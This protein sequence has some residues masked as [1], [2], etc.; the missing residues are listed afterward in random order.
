MSRADITNE[1]LDFY[2]A[3]RDREGNTLGIIGP[4]PDSSLNTIGASRLPTSESEERIRFGY[5]AQNQISSNSAFSYEQMLEISAQARRSIRNI[6][7]DVV[8][9]E[10]DPEQSVNPNQVSGWIRS[11]DTNMHPSIFQQGGEVNGLYEYVRSVNRATAP[12][13]EEIRQLY[14]DNNITES[15]EAYSSLTAERLQQWVEENFQGM[16][17]LPPTIV[18]SENPNLRTA[19]SFNH[20]PD[21]E[22][23]LNQLT[24]Q[25]IQETSA[26]YKSKLGDIDLGSLILDRRS[27]HSNVIMLSGSQMGKIHSVPQS[28][29]EFEYTVLDEPEYKE[30]QIEETEKTLVIVDGVEKWV[31]EVYEE[32][33]KKGAYAV[34]PKIERLYIYRVKNAYGVYFRIGLDTPP[35][36]SQIY[37]GYSNSYIDLNYGPDMYYLLGLVEPEVAGFLD[38]M[39]EF[40]PV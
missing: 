5:P 7:T 1:E 27:D 39:R 4:P 28:I 31:D 15:E 21:S 14:A 37:Y 30:S 12:S 36:N 2:T 33:V 20:I 23:P 26:Q 6:H 16:S 3:L 40:S 9:E 18:D 10:V 32:S 24:E 35:R 25:L 13:V 34:E 29:K 22:F 38:R 8:I 17:S 11:D 19:M